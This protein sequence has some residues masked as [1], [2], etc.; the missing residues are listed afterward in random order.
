MPFT[1]LR[2]GDMCPECLSARLK[3]NSQLDLACEVCGIA[4]RDVLLD[5]WFVP[6]EQPGAMNDHKTAQ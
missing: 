4:S 2:S 1:E 3:Y 5:K 6:W